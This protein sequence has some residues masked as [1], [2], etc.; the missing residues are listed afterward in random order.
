MNNLIKCPSCNRWLIGEEFNSHKCS[1]KI[2]DITYKWWVKTDLDGIGEVL[3][4]EGKDGTLY[5]LKPSSDESLQQDNSKR[6]YDKSTEPEKGII[7]TLLGIGI[8]A[9]LIS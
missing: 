5:R 6:S 3:I 9:S 2:V 4:I 1:C 8:K 7:I